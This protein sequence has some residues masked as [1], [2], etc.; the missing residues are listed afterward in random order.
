M[1]N[2]KGFTIVEL[3]TAFSLSMV[4]MVF[5]FNIVM[6]IKENYLAQSIKSELIVQQGLLSDEL[7]HDA[8]EYTLIQMSGKK[9]E[10]NF[11]FQ[12]ASGNSVM[13][14]LMVTSSSITYSGNGKTYEYQ[15]VDKADPVIEV[16]EVKERTDGMDIGYVFLDISITTPLIENEDFGVKMVYLYSPLFATIDV[17]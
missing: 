11:L 17:S 16:S 9:G 7:A 10:Y 13:K 12:D 6:M 15:F 5:L 8:S 1:K 4:V 14:K 3:L 2:Q